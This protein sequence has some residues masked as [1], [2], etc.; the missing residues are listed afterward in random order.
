LLPKEF[1]SG[2]TCYRGFQEWTQSGIF[3]TLWIRLLKLYDLK[4]GIR[5]NWQSLDSI[6]IKSPPG[7]IDRRS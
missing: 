7:G 5:W 2:S 6:W 1:G 4:K 3:D